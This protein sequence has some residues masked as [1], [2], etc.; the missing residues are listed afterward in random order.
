[1]VLA[2]ASMAIANLRSQ[3]Q[4]ISVDYDA[5]GDVFYIVLGEDGPVESKAIP[6]G[7]DLD[8]RL[9]TE[10]PCGLTILGYRRYGWPNR[11]AE[12]SAIAARHLSMS[13]DVVQRLLAQSS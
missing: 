5:Q 11:V 10:E 4:T 9:D 2:Q 1:M 7:V 8:F 12:L 13:P 6:E 3:Q